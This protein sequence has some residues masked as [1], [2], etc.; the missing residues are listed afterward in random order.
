MKAIVHIGAPKTG[1]ST[2]Q[3]F[4]FQNTD[5]LAQKGFRFSRNV[6]GR[7]SQFEY[8]IAA[9]ARLD[10]LLPAPDTQARHS[11]TD[12][13]VHKQ[14]GA[15]AEAELAAKRATWTEP[16]ALFSSEHIHPWL[17]RT[18]EIQSLDRMFGA[19]FDSVRYILYIRNQEDLVA[20]SHSER[21]KR[22]S[23]RRHQD[24]LEQ[25]LDHLDYE[26]RVRLW[27]DVVG[28]DRFDLRL[29]DPGFLKDGNLLSDFASACG[30]T[31]DGLTI[32][33][34]I[35]ESLSAPAAEC[36]RAMNE[37]IPGTRHDGVRNPLRKGVLERVDELTP[38]D[39]PRI[40]LTEAQ[41]RRI[42]G[43]VGP[44]N[45]ALRA[46]FFPDRESLFQ[47]RPAAEAPE[48]EQILEDA[49]DLM[50]QMFIDLR[51]GKMPVLTP[52]EARLA[53]IRARGGQTAGVAP[54]PAPGDIPP[55]ITAAATETPR[56]R[57]S[58]IGTIRHALRRRTWPSS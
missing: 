29:L 46:R 51:T 41:R 53:V 58:L 17:R 6:P 21:I 56:A 4:L 47:P 44:G 37:R 24:F 16:V 36:V 15:A 19:H 30:F 52:E 40:T 8:P 14:I 9:L 13:A 50:V 39:A 33:P 34:R 32:P 7:G 1:S 49:L 2:I 55:F 35:N 38:A 11:S 3:E 27:L 26:P 42:R 43:R 18:D 54:P 10:R 48:R 23:N 57:R 5:A 31:L 45:E 12:L 20:S 25:R 28:R 22:G